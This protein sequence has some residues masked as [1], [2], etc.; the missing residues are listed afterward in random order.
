M[1]RMPECT[2]KSR[3]PNPDKSPTF[4]PLVK[5]LFRTYLPTPAKA[6]VLSSSDVCTQDWHLF[7]LLTRRSSDL[8]IINWSVRGA[9]AEGTFQGGL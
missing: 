1:K 7:P 2:I 8:G 9:A 4:V 6:V 5:T 3:L